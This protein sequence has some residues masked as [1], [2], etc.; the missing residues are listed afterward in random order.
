MSRRAVVAMT[1]AGLVAAGLPFVTGAGAAGLPAGYPTAGC[2][3]FTDPSGDAPPLNA[4]NPNSDP[5]LDILGVAL[6][7]TAKDLKAYIKVNQL[8]DG[9]SMSTDGHRYTFTF[10]FNGHL[11]SAA[12][13]SFSHGSGA[14]RDGL[15]QTGQ[16]GHSVQLSVD[17]PAVVSTEGATGRASGD[18]GFKDSGL[19]VTWDKANELGSDRRADRR[20]REVR[21]CQVHRQ[22]R[23]CRCPQRHRRVRRLER[24]RHDGGG[25]L[26]Y[27]HRCVAG[28]RQQVLA[29]A[30]AGIEAGA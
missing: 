7:S 22:A 4:N 16:A 24:R 23:V 17:T 5:D 19:T 14:I 29:A 18:L 1:C 27:L 28:R 25:Q 9:P 10:V 13:S 6:Q 8:A 3:D 30:Q 11:F 26:A 15:A 20:H 21:R 2:F 12:G